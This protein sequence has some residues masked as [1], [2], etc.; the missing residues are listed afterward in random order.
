MADRLLGVMPLLQSYSWPGNVRELRNV[1]ERLG[2]LSIDEALPSAIFGRERA[3][4]KVRITSFVDA[5]DR[6]LDQFERHYLIDL[7]KATAG[8]ITQ[9]A[10]IAEVSRRY[11]TRLVAKHKLQGQGR[12]GGGQDQDD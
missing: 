7:L 8:N 4:D 3:P 2:V 11:L 1:V 10:T 9:A 12:G 6:A 5:R